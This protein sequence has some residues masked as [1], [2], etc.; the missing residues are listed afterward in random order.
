[1]KALIGCKAFYFFGSVSVRFRCV[2]E[3]A[4]THN[5]SG[6]SREDSGG[7]LEPT[8][9]V[10]KYPVKMKYLFPYTFIGI[11]PLS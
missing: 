11:N 9:P 7:S 8:P 1:M 6:G 10:F 4:F 3:M 5:S 2:C